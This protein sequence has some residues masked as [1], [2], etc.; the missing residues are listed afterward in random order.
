MVFTYDI[1]SFEVTDTQRSDK[2][3]KPF[4]EIVV[5]NEESFFVV[6]ADSNVWYMRSSRP[7]KSQTDEQDAEYDVM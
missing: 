7:D 5:V 3:I 4:T 1:P 6:K 2:E